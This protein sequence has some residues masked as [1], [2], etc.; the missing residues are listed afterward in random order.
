MDKID[1]DIFTEGKYVESYYP[2]L[3]FIRV[4]TA[5]SA[6]VSSLSFNLPSI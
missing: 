2:L 1:K 4:V 6:T 3:S 5:Y